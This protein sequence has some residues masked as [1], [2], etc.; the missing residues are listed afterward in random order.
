M[1]QI[2][3]AVGAPPVA[4]SFTI[5]P[6]TLA[7]III[8]QSAVTLLQRLAAKPQALQS[9]TPDELRMLAGALASIL[10]VDVEVVLRWPVAQT[11]RAAVVAGQAYVEINGPYL[12]S[13]VVP[14]IEALTAFG[15]SLSAALTATPAAQ[16]P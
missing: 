13:E 5:T 4:T 10:G 6:V 16:T 1:K 7:Q 15:A 12:T 8:L 2:Q 14:A 3:L 11:L 9:L